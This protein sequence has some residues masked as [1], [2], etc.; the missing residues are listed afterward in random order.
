MDT[1][2]NIPR[3]VLGYVAKDS[4]TKIKSYVRKHHLDLNGCRTPAGASVLHLAAEFGSELCLRYLMKM[5]PHLL[6]KPDVR[7]ELPL[8]KAVTY[9]LTITDRANAV[10]ICLDVVEPLLAAYPQAL[11]LPNYK[12]RAPRDL[13]R[14]GGWLVVSGKLSRRTL[15]G[16]LHDGTDQHDRCTAEQKDD[17]FHQKLFD[18]MDDEGYFN[19]F[20][21]D[22]EREAQETYDRWA[23]R[24]DE[25]RR[26]KR[27]QHFEQHEHQRRQGCRQ[28]TADDRQ[29]P[30]PSGD[31][32]S[33]GK[34]VLGPEKPKRVGGMLLPAA[35]KRAR[36]ESAMRQALQRPADAPPLGF[37]EFPW[38]T[39]S[40]STTA[41][42]A[43]MVSILLCDVD[44]TDVTAVRA[45][46]K[47][48]QKT[49]HPD[50]IEQKFG[51]TLLQSA[52]ATIL[53]KVKEIAQLLNAHMQKS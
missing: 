26:Q 19:S 2:Q 24:I 40:G 12:G 9:L 16:N 33:K 39:G 31:S 7:G 45:R 15:S 1:S 38:P 30:P 34:R 11:H 18:N 50:K 4:L 53:D 21:D 47:E 3:K 32:T 29:P 6:G 25:E 46:A 13:L 37:A 51:A 10:H 35:V 44:M 41:A 14:G 8:H 17:L 28:E 22:H 20:D 43:D 48:L 42:A 23:D 36:H 5:Y 49:W 27:R 52:R